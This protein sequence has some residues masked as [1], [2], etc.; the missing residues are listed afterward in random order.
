MKKIL[1]LHK[2]LILCRS[3][4]SINTQMYKYNEISIIWLMEYKSNFI[5][6]HMIIIL[7]AWMYFLM[8][9]LIELGFNVVN[10]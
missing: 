5:L 3:M 2:G 1:A 8:L 10:S 9:H 7:W 6:N 4:K